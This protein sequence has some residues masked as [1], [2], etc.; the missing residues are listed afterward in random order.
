MD[1]EL[2]VRGGCALFMFVFHRPHGAQ[3][4]NVV[5]YGRPYRVGT[6]SHRTAV[7]SSQDN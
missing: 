7:W 6:R 5:S 2:D 3:H 1:Y 4:T